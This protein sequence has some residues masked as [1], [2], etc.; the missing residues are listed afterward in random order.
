MK[1]VLNGIN[2]S[3]MKRRGNIYQYTVNIKNN[4]IFK[5]D[6]QQ[7]FEKGIELLP[8]EIRRTLK[9][10][11]YYLLQE[12]NSIPFNNL[13]FPTSNKKIQIGFLNFD[14]EKEIIDN[15]KKTSKNEF[16]LIT[17]SNKYFLHSQLG[18]LHSEKLDVFNNI[19]IHSDD[20][21]R[22]GLEENEKVLVKNKKHSSSYF[23][24][25]DT[26]L[27]KGVVC[28]HS[29]PSSFLTE[30]NVNHFTPATPEILG[31]SGSYNSAKVKIEKME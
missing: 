7:I 26:S 16:F 12:N 19:Y 24:K 13:Q 23:I 10:K 11:G 3:L 18:E 8:N 14:F 15:L 29:G 31:Y 6:H 22:L 9:Q 30:T 1:V 28:I 17:P 20:L 4:G 27:K 5:L 25:S 2:D 21:E